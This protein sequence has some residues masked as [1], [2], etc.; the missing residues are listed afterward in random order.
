[1]DKKLYV[2]L[3]AVFLLTIGTNLVAQVNVD[4]QGTDDEMFQT[5]FELW[6]DRMEAGE[7]TGNEVMDLV[8]EFHGSLKMMNEEAMNEY[9]YCVD[10]LEN[11]DMTREQ[12]R[13]RL[14]KQ[15]QIEK[16]EK[17]QNRDTLQTGES[18]EKGNSGNGKTNKK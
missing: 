9:Q 13:D 17:L 18:S 2:F 16:E 12:V 5:Q 15:V 11:G 10:Q 14:K 4:N 8:R 1:M 6:L 3:T 7:M